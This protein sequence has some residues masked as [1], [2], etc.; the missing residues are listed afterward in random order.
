MYV[1]TDPQKLSLIKDMLI[2]CFFDVDVISINEIPIEYRGVLHDAV[3]AGFLC[4]YYYKHEGDKEYL[5]KYSIT[6][7]GRDFRDE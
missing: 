4:S 7:K 2:K 1:I 6:P 3:I 5:E